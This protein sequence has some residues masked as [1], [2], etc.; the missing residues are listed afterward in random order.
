M[1]LLHLCLVALFL[2]AF[3]YAVRA[4]SLLVFVPKFHM[5]SSVHLK[6]RAG[7]VRLPLTK[8]DQDP[9]DTFSLS[10]RRQY[11]LHTGMYFEL[12]QLTS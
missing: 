10:Q 4:T 7:L 8:P 12:T 1:N 11:Q 9:D 2:S 5:K 6:D 3:V